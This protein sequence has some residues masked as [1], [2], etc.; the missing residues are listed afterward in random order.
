MCQ[1][2]S[3]H[4]IRIEWTIFVVDVALCALDFGKVQG[5]L[6]S[7]RDRYTYYPMGLLIYFIKFL[8]SLEYHFGWVGCFFCLQEKKC[9]PKFVDLPIFQHV[10]ILKTARDPT[11]Y[12]FLPLVVFPKRFSFCFFNLQPVV[13][14]KREASKRGVSNGGS[15]FYGLL[16][17]IS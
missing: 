13:G 6:S 2:L 4:L 3:S 15:F 11:L 8:A 9:A 17:Y 12:F 16:N 7:I 5:Q 10:N 1:F 14:S